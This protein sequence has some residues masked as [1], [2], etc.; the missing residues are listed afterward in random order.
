MWSFPWSA[1]TAGVFLHTAVALSSSS[2][3]EVAG[4]RSFT[5]PP[6]YTPTPAVPLPKYMVDNQHNYFHAAPDKYNRSLVNVKP[7][8]KLPNRPLA[9]RS[10]DDGILEERQSSGSSYWLANMGHGSFPY[11]PAGYPVWRNV[12]DYGARGDGVTDDT[13][14]IMDAVEDG[15]R[16]GLLCGST[17][18]LGAVV[19]FPPGTYM[20]S[21]PIIQYYFTQ[22]IGDPTNK[23]TIKGL[24]TFQG[25]ALIDTDVYIPGGNGSQWYINQNQ[26]FRQI[27]NFVIDLTAMPNENTSGDQTYVPTGIHWQVAQSTSL[28]NIDVVM[29]LGGGTTAV[30]I[31]TENGS[32]GFMS[33]LTFFGGNIAMRVGSQQFTARHITI[34]LPATAVSMIWNW[35]WTWQDITINSAFVAFDCTNF[36][37]D[38]AQGTGS[39]TVIDSHFISV[40]FAIPVTRDKPPAI[41]L[42]NLLIEGNTPSVVLVSGGETILEGVTGGSATIQSWAMGPRY[43][44]IDGS[45]SS[46]TG[47]INPPPAKPAVLLDGGGS[48]KFFTRSKPQY[49]TLGAG[50]F[51]SVADFGATGDGTGD[52]SGAINSALA[53]A[54]GRVVYFPSGVYPVASTVHVPVG[55]R[56]VGLSW[57][58]LMGVGDAFGNLRDPQP[59]VQVG[60]AGDVGDVEISDMIFTV[61]GST[62]GAVVVEWN[63]RAASQGSAAMW[64]SHVRIGGTVGSDLQFAD[65]PAGSSVDSNCFAAS[66]MMH[67]TAGASGYFEN[68][69]VW[70]ADHDLDVPSQ[71]RINVFVG[72]GLLVEQTDGPVWLWGGA[73]EHATLYQYNFYRA[74]NI[75]AGH[76]Q[77]ESPYYQ[78]TPAATDVFPLDVY[79]SDPDFADCSPTD[80]SCL[81]SWALMI[82]NSSD[83]LIYGAGLYSWFDSYT[84]EC[85]VPEDC[86]SRLVQT[87]YSRRVWM[88]S[89]YTKGATECVSPLGGINAALQRDNRNGFLTAIS[90]WL[91]LSSDAAGNRGGYAS[92]SDHPTPDNLLPVPDLASACG[93]IQPGQTMTL[94]AACASAIR[95]LPTSGANNQPPGPSNC[96]ETC[97]L[98]RLITGT[99]CGVGGS[100]SFGIEVPP[101]QELPGPLPITSG[102]NPGP[103]ATWSAP[104]I[105]STGSPTTNSYDSD[106]PNDHDIWLPPFWIPIPL[107][108]PPLLFPPPVDLPDNDPEGWLIFLDEWDTDGWDAPTP[109]TTGDG[110]GSTPTSTP[111]SPLGITL[112][113]VN[114]L[115]VGQNLTSYVMQRGGTPCDSNPTTLFE[116]TNVPGSP[117]PNQVPVGSFGFTLPPQGFRCSWGNGDPAGPGNVI[118]TEGTGTVVQ[119]ACSRA[120]GGSEGTCGVTG[121]LVTRYVAQVVC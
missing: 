115:A 77:T 31:F 121:V 21:S 23:P 49:E 64:D 59:V 66:L 76:I 110:G 112:Y 8:P 40:P 30:G 86:Q 56:I 74:S 19:F 9:S 48:G 13:Q 57:P 12:K 91:T 20:V 75:F 51:V 34:T 3:I 100:A 44:D 22:F 33:D 25:I 69:W 42:D 10:K 38:G 99:C 88:F 37:G 35:G 71:D 78:P 73:V 5:V 47:H 45:G 26:F 106:D 70:T 83:V 82:S 14:A 102:F 2:V 92:V 27:R 7:P 36:G 63:V 116:Q 117:Q 89:Q 97:N 87:S 50:S 62:A 96:Q 80:E 72:R 90:A 113:W 93:N 65:C 17:S 107:G 18:V 39:L 94:S 4:G 46:V 79:A 81:Y 43:T 29:P 58:Q 103:S 119:H 60:N 1:V 95:S 114:Q 101:G 68:D 67:I 52:Q 61:R 98:Y 41:T 104:G 28:Q 6:G 53:A 118:C 109:T 54:N 105:D 108:G 84:Q 15:G 55:S 120:P 85:L 11:A 24:P 16:C 111:P 32:G